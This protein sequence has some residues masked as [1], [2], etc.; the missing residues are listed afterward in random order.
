MNHVAER[1]GLGRSPPC[2]PSRPR[3][4]PKWLMDRTRRYVALQQVE[5]WDNVATCQDC[6][7]RPA[8]EVKT[9][10][11][12][13]F[14]LLDQLVPYSRAIDCDYF[15]KYR[16]PLS[17]QTLLSICRISRRRAMLHEENLDSEMREAPF[18]RGTNDVYLLGRERGAHDCQQRRHR[19]TFV[20]E[21]CSA[22]AQAEQC[23]RM[24]F[25]WWWLY[26]ACMT[27]LH[28][29][30]AYCSTLTSYTRSRHSK[31]KP[32]RFQRHNYHCWPVSIWWKAD[33]WLCQNNSLWT[34]LILLTHAAA[35]MAVPAYS[36]GGTLT[37]DTVCADNWIPFPLTRRLV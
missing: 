25:T 12:L 18:G 23:S 37:C 19:S 36:C 20:F 4:T 27:P 9:W 35:P 32:P 3:P 31:T 26:L 7:W 34:S 5:V 2:S 17:R 24:G 13:E 30:S 15:G 1:L 28:G 22:A 14:G 16:S 10:K 29:N 21:W 6:S 8:F 11:T 33:Y